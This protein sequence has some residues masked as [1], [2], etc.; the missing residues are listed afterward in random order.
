MKHLLRVAAVQMN[1]TPD[2]ARNLAQAR[3]F[4]LDAV[5]D[6]AMFIAFPENFTLFARTTAEFLDGAETLHDITVGTLQEWAAEYGVWILAGSL[7]LKINR[8][9]KR[10]TN[11]SLLLAPNGDIAARYDKIHL[12]DACLP[13]EKAY[14]ES[15]YVRPGRRPV[16]ARTPFGGVGLSICYDVR[17]PELYRQMTRK[18]ANDVHLITVPA[19]FTAQ[20]G[21]AHWDVLTRARAIENQAFLIAPA[22]VGSPFPGRETYG[23][24]RIVDPWGQVLAEKKTGTGVILAELDP[25]TLCQARQKVPALANRRL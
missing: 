11:T 1:S 8:E 6:K 2:K 15:D 16:V 10:V 23:H 14:R 24:T 19:A 13:G 18:G 25:A 9:K 21:K 22:Q 5:K 20:T 7:P 3:R 12:F 17:F 4:L